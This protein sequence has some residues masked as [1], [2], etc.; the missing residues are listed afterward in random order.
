MKICAKCKK[1]QPDD[2]YG[3]VKKYPFTVDSGRKQQSYCNPCRVIYN[4]EM[5][6]RT[7][8]EKAADQRR[9]KLKCNYG[10][11]LDDKKNQLDYQNNQ[12]AICQTDLLD[13]APQ[14]VHIDHCHGSK[15]L[16]GILCGSCNTGLGMFKDTHE[17]LQRAIDYLSTDGVWKTK[18]VKITKF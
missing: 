2:L 7:L 11:T 5:D 17:I 9:L 10:L 13:R 4:Q 8:K 16:R 1:E 3:T 18:R 15:K 14:S 12:C 6:Y